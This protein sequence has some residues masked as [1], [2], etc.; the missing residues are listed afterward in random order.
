MYAVWKLCWKNLKNK[1]VQ[2]SF[3]AI[4]IMLAA[5]LLSTA[6]LVITNTNRAYEN[7]HSKVDGAH[8]ILQMENGI[9]NP[10]RIQ[11]WW[12]KQ[13]GVSASD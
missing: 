10:V 4:I 3:I 9:Q 11:Q 12:A 1:K 7:M 6:V 8:Q 5:L 2:N 13:D